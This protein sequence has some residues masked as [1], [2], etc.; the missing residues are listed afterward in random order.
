MRSFDD[1]EHESA[2]Q[3]VEHG[4]G[5]ADPACLEPL[6]VVDTDR[7]QRGHLFASQSF[8]TPAATCPE[9]DVLRLDP[10]AP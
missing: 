7:G 1:V 3:R 6:D 10:C 5:G 2:G 9:A 8:D 4:V